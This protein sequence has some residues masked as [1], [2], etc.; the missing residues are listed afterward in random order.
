MRQAALKVS[1]RSTV[2]DLGVAE[3]VLV[4]GRAVVRVGQDNPVL[5]VKTRRGVFAVN[6]R[7]PH[8]ALPLT[9]ASVRRTLLK[10]PFHG[11]EFDMASGA[12]R[13]ALRSR[14]ER[15][16]TY[17]AWVAD[18]HLFLDLAANAP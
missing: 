9:S 14:T 13:G 8:L 4:G 3:E 10:C 15:L 5:I 6:N 2:L 11:R 16:R 17:R 12:G 7:C 1:K 18:D